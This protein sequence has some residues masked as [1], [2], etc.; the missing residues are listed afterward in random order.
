MV[1]VILEGVVKEIVEMKSKSGKVYKIIQ[2]DQVGHS[3]LHDYVN[4]MSFNGVDFE[5]GEPVALRCSAFADMDDK[6]NVKLSF[7]IFEK[8]E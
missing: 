5:T 1:E 7:R 2:I 3:G 4:V 6:G 8:R